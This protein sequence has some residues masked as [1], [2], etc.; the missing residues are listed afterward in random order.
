VRKACRIPTSTCAAS[1]YLT[2]NA[3]AVVYQGPVGM[4][5]SIKAGD[6][7][8]NVDNKA[9]EAL[10]PEQV[11][12][13]IKGAP[14]SRVTLTLLTPPPGTRYISFSIKRTDTGKIGLSFGTRDNTDVFHVMGFVEGLPAAASGLQLGDLIHEID[15]QLV[16]G[17]SVGGV[18]ALIKGETGLTSPVPMGVFRRHPVYA[19]ETNGGVSVQQSR[20]PPTIT[21]IAEQAAKE[22]AKESEK[23][24]PVIQLIAVPGLDDFEDERFGASSDEEIEVLLALHRAR[25]R[26]A[27]RDVLLRIHFV[28]AIDQR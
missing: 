17:I 23:E 1:Q 24:R 15:G 4:N 2:S 5:G 25:A 28:F 27:F 12:N 19:G 11:S 3:S 22:K 10:A 6:Y 20:A 16:Y 26:T 13:L 21:I 7:I 14:G 8:V 18:T 9:I